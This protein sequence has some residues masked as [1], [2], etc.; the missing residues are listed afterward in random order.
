MA[1]R[2]FKQVVHRLPRVN[3]T[4]T[5]FEYGNGYRVKHSVVT[6]DRDHSTYL[7]GTDNFHT[8]EKAAVKEF[9]LL[10]TAY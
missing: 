6:N 1:E 2:M 8:E 5:I 9:E 4:N 7:E 3:I 10:A